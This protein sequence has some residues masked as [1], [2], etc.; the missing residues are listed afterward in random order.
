MCKA[1]VAGAD[2]AELA[3]QGP[4]D[5]KARSIAGQDVF[6][7][8]ETCGKPESLKRLFSDNIYRFSQFVRIINDFDKRTNLR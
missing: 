8:L 1:F 2:I 3:K 7:H 4:I 6:R 5:G